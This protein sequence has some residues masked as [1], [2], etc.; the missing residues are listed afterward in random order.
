M[1]SSAAGKAL[2]RRTGGGFSH[3]HPRCLQGCLRGPVAY[4]ISRP[5]TQV[6][7]CAGFSAGLSPG[8]AIIE[9]SELAQIACAPIPIRDLIEIACDLYAKAKLP[10]LIATWLDIGALRIFGWP[11]SKSG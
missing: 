9:N 8:R 2:F 3:P 6:A 11:Q 1:E 4:S 10:V 5:E 7:D